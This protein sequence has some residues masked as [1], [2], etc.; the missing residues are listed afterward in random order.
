MAKLDRRLIRRFF[1]LL[2]PECELWQSGR[3]RRGGRRGVLLTP[4]CE[5]WQ[6]PNNVMVANRRVLLTPECELW[7]SLGLD[8]AAEMLSC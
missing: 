8:T 4:E 7:Q 5:L 6:S 3:A 1:V 2:T